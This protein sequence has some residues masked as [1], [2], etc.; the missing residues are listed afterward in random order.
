MSRPPS[1]RAWEPVVATGLWLAVVGVALAL[2]PPLPMDETRYFAVAWEMWRDGNFLVPHLNG[3]PYSHKP[4]LLFWMMQAGWAVLGVN[5]GWPRLVAPLFGLANLFLTASLARSLWPERPEVARLAP[6]LL[7]GAAFWAVFTTLTMFDMI[8]ATFALAGLLGVVRAW[9]EGSRQGWILLVAAIGFGALAKGPAILLHVLPAAWLAPWWGRNWRRPEIGTGGWTLRVL[10]A[11]T[12]GAAL[13]LAWA[14]PAGIAG[15]EEY[16]N[17]IFWGQSAGRMVESFDHA[18]PWWWYLA[19]L[20]GLLF[21]WV[22][23]PRL[24]QALGRLPDAVG[25]AGLRLCLAWFL[26]ALVAFS[27]ISGKQL[28]YLLPFFPALALAGARLLPA[29]AE[30]GRLGW[31]PG[32]LVLLVAAGVAILPL[33]VRHLPRWAEGL[34][35]GWMVIVVVAGIA[36]LFRPSST[37]RRAFLLAL[38][39][40]ALVIGVH[41]VGARKVAA[42]FDL[43][44]FSQR[45]AEWER[46][47][48]PLANYGKYHGQFHF[49]GRLQYPMAIIGDQEIAA[50]TAAHPGGVIVTYQKSAR[51]EPGRLAIQPFRGKVI[52]AWDASAVRERPDLVSR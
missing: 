13:A 41:L 29:R 42:E 21:P 50:W 49:A 10:A 16:R 31:L 15:G 23:W 26:P 39:P 43:R 24:W 35:P 6:L 3:V 47:G 4:P 1:S 46:A 51:S 11:V 18:R 22:L 37:A 7:F 44:P 2:R 14:L 9:R 30:E 5:D 12:G 8:L 27:L 20:P 36:S 25:D 52:S 17:A 40:T 48:R 32:L 34:E 28:H 45:L 19:L 38:L 33:A